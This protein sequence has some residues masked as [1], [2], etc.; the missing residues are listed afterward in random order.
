MPWAKDGSSFRKHARRVHTCKC[1]RQIHGNAFY[2]HT[3]VCPA[4]RQ[5]REEKNFDLLKHIAGEAK[6]F[7]AKTKNH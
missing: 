6:E 1:G 4:Y 3:K 7:L 2:C 5:W